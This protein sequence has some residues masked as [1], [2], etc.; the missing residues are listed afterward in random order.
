MAAQVKVAIRVDRAARSAVFDFTGTS[1]QRPDNFNAP[2]A[3]ARAASLY[4]VR[5]LMDEDIPLN[6]GCLRPV[7]ADP[8][9]GARC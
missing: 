3:I 2:R 8:A 4:V 5:T 1:P 7:D 9:R 6:D